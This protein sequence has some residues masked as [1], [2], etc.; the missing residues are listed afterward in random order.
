MPDLKSNI[1]KMDALRLKLYLSMRLQEEFPGCFKH[2]T[3]K[4]SV[5]GNAFNP[6]GL[7]LK[8]TKGNGETVERPA[9]QVPSILWGDTLKRLMGE[10]RLPI[11]TLK[12]Y[13]KKLEEETR[14]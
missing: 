6:A 13:R 12:L 9:M 14:P 10:P 8:L 1:E 5:T 4:V 7:V 3:C 2:G 11:V